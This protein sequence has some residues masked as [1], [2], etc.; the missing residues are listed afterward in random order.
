[1]SD[2]TGF[3]PERQ[4]ADQTRVE[5]FFKPNLNLANQVL[6][7]R[8]GKY[9]QNLDA[10]A[11]AKAKVSEVNSL[12]GYDRNRWYEMQKLYDED[13]N[14]VMGLYNGDLSKADTELQGFLNKV[15]KDFGI[16][17]EATAINERALGYMQNKKALDERYAEGKITQ[18]QYWRLQD[19]L[20]KT[21]DIG[22][23]T[24][25]KAYNPWRKINPMDAINF[26]KFA[27]EFLKN[28]EADLRSK[29]YTRSLEGD[30]YVWRKSEH[31]FINESELLNEL[32]TAYRNAAE[33]TGQLKDDFAYNAY[34]SNLEMTKKTWTD[35][36]TGVINEYDQRINK[37]KTLKGKELQEY[38]ISMGYPLE[39]GA[40]GIVGSK[41]IAAR[42]ALIEQADK[43]KEL[44]GQKIEDINS[45]NEAEVEKLYYDDYVDKETTKLAK[46][47]AGAKSFDRE[48][49][50][51]DIRQDPWVEFRIDEA[52][53]D[54][55]ELRNNAKPITN[56]V[57]GGAS[58][59]V[60]NVKDAHKLKVKL[61]RDIQTK[62][63]LLKDKSLSPAERKKIE[64][65]IRIAEAEIMDINAGFKSIDARM[66]ELGLKTADDI[67][68]EK[69]LSDKQLDKI[70]NQ[71]ERGYGDVAD[72]D[73]LDLVWSSLTEEER[74]KAFGT[75]DYSKVIYTDTPAPGRGNFN[76][77]NADKAVRMLKENKEL[78]EAV[79]TR[80]KGY[81]YRESNPFSEDINDY[82]KKVDKRERPLLAINRVNNAI[83]ENIRTYNKKDA[84]DFF[85]KNLETW[86]TNLE[87]GKEGEYNSILR[88]ETKNWLTDL[89]SGAE[90]TDD[91]GNDFDIV[92][93]QSDYY[94]TDSDGNPVETTVSMQNS[95][96]TLIKLPK[97]GKFYMLFKPKTKSGDPV[98]EMVGGKLQEASELVAPANQESY[99]GSLRRAALGEIEHGIVEG[100]R[101]R[102]TEGLE[103]LGN[104]DVLPELQ[105]SGVEVMI[106]GQAPTIVDLNPDNPN[107]GNVA[108]VKGTITKQGG[109]YATPDSDY[110]VYE[111][112]GQDERGN[113]I[114][115]SELELPVN[116][117][118]PGE[119]KSSNTFGSAKEIATGIKYMQLFGGNEKPNLGN[120]INYG[121]THDYSFGNERAIIRK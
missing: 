4:G 65:D 109:V 18:G 10:M 9:N 5:L 16:H 22:I 36:W 92:V 56:M 83:S 76:I 120:L 48:K 78:K 107:A 87:G 43:Y 118:G 60:E 63:E 81:Y 99:K 58:I 33:K 12:E 13:I 90:Y 91:Y 94:T 98:Y 59:K 70:L 80:I 71:H 34:A 39:G 50:F 45:F 113:P 77:E 62:K 110:R 20:E 7:T 2:L 117:S 75:N 54:A 53:K 8:Q 88:T 111:V 86:E 119:F 106:P 17:G 32:K 116:I 104:T 93:S 30:F 15:G 68:D 21:K 38:I 11:K 42:K 47:Y 46:P 66:K 24:D 19:E 14:N 115:G 23:G 37:L 57:S 31:E 96:G 6:A 85:T 44:Y 73:I 28:K 82:R 3:M 40:D 51:Q 101:G 26:D 64:K 41:T 112:K 69:L 84:I 102:F 25:P 97:N 29:G 89:I 67:I 35:Q 95:S 1:M 61:K 74:V 108:I 52:G 49:I 72:G 121:K 79:R 55:D 27:N 105:L 114:Y 100:K 103:V